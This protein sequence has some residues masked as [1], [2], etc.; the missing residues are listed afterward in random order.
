MTEIICYI[1]G[2]SRSCAAKVAQVT[3]EGIVLGWTVFYRGVG[4]QPCDIGKI[5][6]GENERKVDS[7]CRYE[8]NLIHEMKGGFPESGQRVILEV[9][10]DR[11][12]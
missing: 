6:G 7:V 9:D 4:G 5:R 11:R 1:D 3:G 2:Y 8:G 10:W 12:Y